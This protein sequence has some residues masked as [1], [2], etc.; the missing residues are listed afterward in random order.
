MFVAFKMKSLLLNKKTEEM[1]MV[2]RFLK[3]MGRAGYKK[4]GSQGLEEFVSFIADKDLK[5]SAYR[6]VTNF[7]KIF[8][9][10]K[11]LNR[12]DIK[13]LNNIIKDIEQ[14]E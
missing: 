13:N 12:Q 6:F 5:N 3:S 1:K 8:Y 9:K 2:S 7:E 11:K 14:H 4:I 10:D